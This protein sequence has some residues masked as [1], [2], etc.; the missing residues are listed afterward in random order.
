MFMYVAHCE[1]SAIRHAEDMAVQIPSRH[2]IKTGPIQ[3][4]ASDKCLPFV[5]KEDPM[6]SWLPRQYTRISG[7]FLMHGWNQ[8]PGCEETFHHNSHD[9][10]SLMSS[11]KFSR[12]SLT[13]LQMP[14]T[15]TS[16]RGLMPQKNWVTMDLY[17]C[18]SFKMPLCAPP[19][20]LVLRQHVSSPAY[21]SVLYSR[22]PLR[23]RTRVYYSLQ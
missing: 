12:I 9:H 6:M 11:S 22:P 18:V 4:L 21:L 23:Q 17:K 16:Q 15:T 7:L 20:L 13:F 14:P 10:F 19:P 3:T 8:I 5:C 2:S 1:V